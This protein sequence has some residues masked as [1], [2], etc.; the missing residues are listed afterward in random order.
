MMVE[1]GVGVAEALQTIANGTRQ[2]RAKKIISVMYHRVDEG[3]PLWKAMAASRA[4]PK[5][6]IS[7][8]GLGEKSGNLSENLKLIADQQEKQRLFRSR[9]R[10]ASIYPVF[11]LVLATVLGLGIA[12]FLLPRLATVFTSLRIPL[13]LI[14]RIL[15]FIGNFLKLYG[16]VFVPSVLAALFLIVMFLFVIPGT[17]KIGQGL[18]FRMPGIGRLIQENQIASFGYLYGALLNAGLNPA[19]ALKA[20]SDASEYANYQKLYAKLSELITDGNSFKKSFQLIKKSYR[21]V[22]PYV[23]QMIFT[24]EKSGSLPQT[25]SRIGAM[26]EAKAESTAKNLSVLLEPIALI[27]VWLAVMFVALA[28]IVPIYSLIGGFNSRR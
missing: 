7:L 5:H 25:F 14:T 4:F 2:A 1:A 15:I 12:W 3:E 9:I 20:L 19:Q 21:L 17:K 23:Q 27:I 26:Y 11:V 18:M 6:V 13:P 28:V 22:P 24:A 8:V 10:S 16:V